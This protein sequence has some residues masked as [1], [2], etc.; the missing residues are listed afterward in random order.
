MVQIE[1][2]S[3]VLKFKN[4]WR[5]G[6]NATL[7]AKYNAGKAKVHLNVELGNAPP[8]VSHSYLS[9]SRDGPARQRHHY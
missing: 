2:G 8:M 9:R 7:S 6:R 5:S 3:F 4:L 1:L